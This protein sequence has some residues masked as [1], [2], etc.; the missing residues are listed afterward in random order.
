[1]A[2]PEVGMKKISKAEN[3]DDQFE[4]RV[5]AIVLKAIEGRGRIYREILTEL[6]K[7][8]SNMP[9]RLRF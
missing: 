8:L 9:G 7:D 6:Q 3:Q 1:M 5:I 4:A 2:E